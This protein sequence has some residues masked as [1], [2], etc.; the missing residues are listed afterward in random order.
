MDPGLK[1]VYH[2][3]DGNM[4]V[5]SGKLTD[6]LHSQLIKCTKFQNLRIRECT[7]VW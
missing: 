1:V 4:N 5:H 3:Y 6:L 7:L 2:V